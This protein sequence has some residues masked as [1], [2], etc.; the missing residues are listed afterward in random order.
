MW[1]YIERKKEKE[2]WEKAWQKWFPQRWKA[3]LTRARGQILR[4]LS[5]MVNVKPF[6]EKSIRKS[7][8]RKLSAST[9]FFTLDFVFY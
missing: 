2:R 5:W 8:S 6:K 9:L 1:L 3:T 7:V 4:F